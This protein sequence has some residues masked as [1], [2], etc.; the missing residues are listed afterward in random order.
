MPSRWAKEFDL[1]M[2]E[3]EKKAEQESAVI[4]KDLRNKLSNTSE[5]IQRLLDVYLA[6]DIDRE[7]YLKER[8]KLFSD[9]KSFEEKM[10]K[11]EKDAK[12]WLEPMQEWLNVASVLAEAAQSNDLSSKKSLIPKIFGS[13]PTLHHRRIPESVIPPYA[14]LRAACQKFSENEMSFIRVHLYYQIRTYFR[15]HND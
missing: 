1:L 6:Q 9:K 13:N 15:E 3:D 10:Y 8:S 5:K 7:T 11:L 2:K 12:A 14:A 4:I